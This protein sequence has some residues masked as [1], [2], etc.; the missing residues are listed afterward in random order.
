M[1]GEEKMTTEPPTE[2]KG[3]AGPTSVSRRRFLA[4][5]GV[6][7][8]VGAAGATG[9]MVAVGP[10][11]EGPVVTTANGQPVAQTIGLPASMRKVAL[12]INGQVLD[13]T[14]D[15]RSSL[16]EVMT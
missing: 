14:V 9:V 4:G 7:L 5:A 12:N 16:W 3:S 8:A 2:S 13:V 1:S 10:K 11:A 15:V 6:G